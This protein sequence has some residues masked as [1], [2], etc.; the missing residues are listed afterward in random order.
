[1]LCKF[2][3][4]DIIKVLLK[5]PPYPPLVHISLIVKNSLIAKLISLHMIQGGGHYRRGELVFYLK[6]ISMISWFS[7]CTLYGP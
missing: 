5:P 1:M 7:S 2:N 4:K 3:I 6:F